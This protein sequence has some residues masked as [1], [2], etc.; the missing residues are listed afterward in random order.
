MSEQVDTGRYIKIT[1]TELMAILD[2]YTDEDV[3]E[4]SEAGDE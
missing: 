3:I 1:P 4:D 2:R